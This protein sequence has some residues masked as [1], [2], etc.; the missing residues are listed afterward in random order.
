[1]M[2]S[3]RVPSPMYMDSVYPCPLTT[4]QRTA[5][6]SGVAQWSATGASGGSTGSPASFHSSRPP[7]ML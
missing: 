1:M 6:E 3:N 2:M 4:T 5:P 7:A